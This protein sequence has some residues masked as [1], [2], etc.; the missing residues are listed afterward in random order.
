MS[1]S[2]THTL[3]LTGVSQGAQ[4]A[5]GPICGGSGHGGRRGE[6][7]CPSLAQWSPGEEKVCGGGC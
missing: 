4:G 1:D 5:E 6:M 7:T 3:Q 2:K